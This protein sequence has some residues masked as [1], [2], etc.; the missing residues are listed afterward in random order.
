[1]WTGEVVF[2]LLLILTAL[3]SLQQAIRHNDLPDAESVLPL[4]GI[5]ESLPQT[6]G[7]FSIIFSP[8]LFEEKE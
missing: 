2:S 4:T 3:A 5:V 6:M 8:H 7:F 1:M